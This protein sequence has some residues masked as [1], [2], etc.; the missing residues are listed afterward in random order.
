M[1]K[2]KIKLSL[3]LNATNEKIASLKT[4]PET[5]EKEKLLHDHIY[6]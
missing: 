6:R 4:R 3:T 5:K 2:A 1:T